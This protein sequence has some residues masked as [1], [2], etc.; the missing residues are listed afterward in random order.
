MQEKSFTAKFQKFQPK[1]S[2]MWINRWYIMSSAVHHPPEKLS[3]LHGQSE[4]SLCP[5]TGTSR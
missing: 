4:E 1:A 3:V 2:S 5:K